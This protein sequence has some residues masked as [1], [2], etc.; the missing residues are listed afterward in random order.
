MVPIFEMNLIPR[1][2]DAVSE[3]VGWPRLL[4][5]TRRIW[6]SSSLRS[7]GLGQCLEATPVQGIRGVGNQLAQEYPLLE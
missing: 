4:S 7:S 2:A 3:M 5:T 1:H 6:V